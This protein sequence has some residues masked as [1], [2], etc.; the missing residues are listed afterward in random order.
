[1]ELLNRL[2]IPWYAVTRLL[3]VLMLVYGLLFDHTGERGT[4]ILSALG[5]MGLE[6]VARTDSK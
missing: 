3:G 4:I 2:N 6:K 1:M 5:L